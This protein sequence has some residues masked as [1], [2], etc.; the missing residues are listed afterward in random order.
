MSFFTQT[1]YFIK[2]TYLQK[3]LNKVAYYIKVQKGHKPK[4]T[5]G[6]QVTNERL[7]RRHRRME[8]EL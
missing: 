6:G 2:E 7:Q 3:V 4:I 1:T 5:T 8:P